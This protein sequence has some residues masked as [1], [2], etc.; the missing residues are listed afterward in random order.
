MRPLYEIDPDALDLPWL[1]SPFTEGLLRAST[2]DAD[3]LARC[4]AYAQRGYT[5]LDL[6]LPDEVFD[7]LRTRLEGRYRGADAGRIRDAWKAED[8]VL[9]DAL[10]RVVNHGAVL[11]LLRTLY[12]REPA[13]CQ[14]LNFARGPQQATHSDAVHFRASS[15]RFLCG[16]WVALEDIHPDAGPLHYLPGSHRLPIYTPGD[17]Q[18]G[19]RRP[20]GAACPDRLMPEYERFIQ[21]LTRAQGLEREVFRARRG[22]A[23]VW[24]ANLL[25]GSEPIRDPRLSRQSM[26]THYLME[27]GL[28]DAAPGL[29]AGVGAVA[30][31]GPGHSRSGRTTR[32]VLQTDR[33]LRILVWPRYD[34]DA[35]LRVLAEML[36]GPLVDR[37]DSC[38]CIRFDPERDAVSL[39]E[40]VRRLR[41]ALGDAAGKGEGCELL[42]VDDP[43]PTERLGELHDQVT[44]VF[45]LPRTEP[46]RRALLERV[47]RPWIRSVEELESVLIG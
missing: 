3:T 37:G 20:R 45:E 29:R 43:I 24:S 4:R 12:R 32:L 36:Q 5:T 41:P 33:P 16:V 17:L 7:A 19:S 8:A 10:L 42:L 34:C 23:I 1:E 27:G 9:R 25:H 14:T 31:R 13:P 22:Q 2:L 44:A 15:A 18:L 40:A 26:V 35:D 39:D 38:L 47:A 6:D 21:S 46:A 28:H 30:L 11:D